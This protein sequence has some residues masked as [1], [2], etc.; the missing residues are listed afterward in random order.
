MT[1]EQPLT[2]SQGETILW[3]GAPSPAVLGMWL[4]TKVLPFVVGSTFLVFWAM[5][6]FGGMWAMSSGA[7]QNFNPF[8]VAGQ[9]L[10]KVAPLAFLLACLYCWRLRKTYRYFITNQRAVFAGGLVVEKRRSVHYHKIT[11][12]EVSRNLLEQAFGLASLRIFTA[13]STRGYASWPWGGDRAE[14]TFPGLRDTDKA[15]GILNGRLKD[16]RSTGE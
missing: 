14:I 10:P 1:A 11:D 6:L 13:G 15:E 2:L 4:A 8:G 9:V 12:I 7:G 5:G 3:T 16:Y